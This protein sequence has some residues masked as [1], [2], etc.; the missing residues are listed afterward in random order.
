MPLWVVIG[1]LGVAVIY[2]YAERHMFWQILMS[3]GVVVGSTEGA[4]SGF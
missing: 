3:M 4:G 1:L 2:G